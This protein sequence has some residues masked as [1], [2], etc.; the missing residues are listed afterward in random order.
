[1]AFVGWSTADYDTTRD[2]L[3][4]FCV[5]GHGGWAS[6][7]CNTW[8]MA[9]GSFRHDF[10]P[11]LDLIPPL[12]QPTPGIVIGKEAGGVPYYVDSKNA[13]PDHAELDSAGNRSYPNMRQTYGGMV[14]MPTVQRYF[15]WGGFVWWNPRGAYVPSEYDPVTKKYR[16]LDRDHGFSY[17][18]ETSYACWDSILNRVIFHDNDNLWAYYPTKAFGSRV[19]SL[20]SRR[21]EIFDSNANNTML[22]D[23]KRNRAVVMGQSAVS[24]HGG[25]IAI[26]DFT[27]NSHATSR[28]VVSSIRGDTGIVNAPGPGFRYD[29]LGDRYV[30]WNGG[31]TLYFV[32]PDTWVF[33]GY[34]PT[35]GDMPTIPVIGTNPGGG[36]WQRFFYS[37][38][39]DVF[40]VISHA[41][42]P[43]YIFAPAR[44]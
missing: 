24:H 26:Y 22:F 33:A 3:P 1:M 4:I 12:G 8:E 19:Q 10:D 6:N 23:P 25:G 37:P 29:P 21:S 16:V 2:E 41:N 17:S 38:N 13:Y 20:N 18:C 7:E 42:E 28:Q 40:G 9:T 35:G 32:N 36:T 44:T 43:A 34:T 27:K 30:G 5:A 11:T 14:Y 39:Y 15:F 31:K